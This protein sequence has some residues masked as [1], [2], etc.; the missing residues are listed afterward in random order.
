M[1][2]TVGFEHCT[3]QT[4]TYSVVCLTTIP[5]PEGH[6]TAQKAELCLRYSRE[7][8]MKA[9]R[10]RSDWLIGVVSHL[11][12]PANYRTCPSAP[13]PSLLSH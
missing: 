3:V 2:L 4:G 12:Y 6:H 1:N 5:A 7:A 11:V 13:P 8:F 10:K 9:G